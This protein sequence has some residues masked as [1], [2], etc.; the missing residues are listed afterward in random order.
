MILSIEVSQ[1]VESRL[2]ETSA[3]QGLAL[4]ECALQALV[5][6][7]GNTN[8]TPTMTIAEVAARQAEIRALLKAPALEREAAIQ[9]SREAAAIYYG[10]VTGRDELADWRN[11]DGEEFADD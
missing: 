11:L 3:R 2:M 10:T 6:G 7:L 5:R 9:A 1:E 8:V 4:H